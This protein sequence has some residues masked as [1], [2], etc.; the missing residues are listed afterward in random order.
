MLQSAKNVVRV[1]VA[2]LRARVVAASDALRAAA[3]GLVPGPAPV[4]VPVRVRNRRSD[5]IG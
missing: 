2:A 1:K 4:L 3:I 5:R